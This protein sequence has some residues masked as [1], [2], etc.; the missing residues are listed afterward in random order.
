MAAPKANS[1]R[2]TK[3]ARRAKAEIVALKEALYESL[4]RDHPQTCRQLFYELSSRLRLIDKTENQY[5]GTVVRLLGVMRRE[6]MIPY[7]WIADATRW[8]RKETS[9]R[10]LADALRFTAQ[11][12][13]RDLWANQ[14]GYV[15]VWIEKDAL[16][17]VVYEETNKYDVPLMVAR[18][19]SSLTFLHSAGE[20]IAAERKPAW[21][22]YFGDHDPSGVWIDRKIEQGL[23]THAPK[24]EI[25]FERVAVLRE[26]IEQ[27]NLPTRPTKRSDTR[28]RNFRGDSVE[29]DAIPAEQLRALV[30]DC[31]ERHIDPRRLRATER[32][33][34]EERV[35]LARLAGIGE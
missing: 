24:A 4:E 10:S 3:R 8:M 11:T 19:F 9:H 15:E 23:R 26:Q 16:A 21:I 33:E 1:P 25:H 5:K 6:G 22:Y 14:K 17:G 34:A 27:W 7:R 20:A 28:A 18:G 30:R 32:I 29:L 13:R 2:P 12:Y 35:T 31:I